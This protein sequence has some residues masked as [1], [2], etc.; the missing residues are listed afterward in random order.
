MFP[1]AALVWL[2]NPPTYLFFSFESWIIF[3]TL[4]A[5]TCILRWHRRWF[6]RKTDRRRKQSPRARP[7]SNR[8][9]RNLRLSN[10]IGPD[11]RYPCD[12]ILPK[13]TVVPP[14]SPRISPKTRQPY[15]FFLVLDVEATCQRGADFNFPNEI[16]VSES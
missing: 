14:T 2:L 16:I 8:T 11:M 10:G 13:S 6:S 3:A 15:E 7:P 4:I 1:R 5:A 9:S 12:V